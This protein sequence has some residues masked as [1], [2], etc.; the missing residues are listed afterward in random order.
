VGVVWY[1]KVTFPMTSDAVE[2]FVSQEM[3]GLFDSIL[4]GYADC[5]WVNPRTRL[6]GARPKISQLQRARDLGFR[7]PDT[8]VTTNV[9]AL[10]Q[11]ADRHRGQI[12]AKPIQA[13]VIGSGED[14][15][16]VGTRHLTPKYFESAVSACPCYAQERLLLKSEIRVVAFGSQLYS[17]RLTAKEKADDLKQLK[18]CQID[19]TRCE[20][21]EGTSRKVHSLMSFYGLEFGA[22]D[23]AVTDEEDPIF[24]ELNPNGQWL[25]LQYMTG[26]NLID[27][28]IDLLCS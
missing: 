19:H 28:F 18:L 24:L 1:R 16:I 5:R 4:A 11:F 27:P 25:W 9:D 21:D 22:I 10:K 14:A 2:S 6:A 20:L 15:L 17:F 12:V 3:Q 26:E 7:I 23:L 13:Q 8:L